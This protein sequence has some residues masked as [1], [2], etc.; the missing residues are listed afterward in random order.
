[1][2]EANEEIDDIQ[3]DSEGETGSIDRFD[4]ESVSTS[5]SETSVKLRTNFNEVWIWYENGASKPPKRL[6]EVRHQGGCKL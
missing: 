3:F 1:M 2:L 6:V 4:G 5:T